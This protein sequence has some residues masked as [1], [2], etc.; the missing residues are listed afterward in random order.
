LPIDHQDKPIEK[1]E[2]AK[3]GG[4]KSS[5]RPNILAEL[6]GLKDASPRKLKKPTTKKVIK[7]MKHDKVDKADKDEKVIT[8]SLNQI[9]RPSLNPNLITDHEILAKKPNTTLAKSERISLQ[10]L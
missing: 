5:S 7:V 3:R 2:K 4:M 10:P 8:I 1:T 6:R 9:S